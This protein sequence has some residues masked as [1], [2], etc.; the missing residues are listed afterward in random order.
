[1]YEASSPPSTLRKVR[2]YSTLPGPRGAAAARTR[3]QPP[4]ISRQEQHTPPVQAPS[5]AA[6]WD[7]AGALL[8]PRLEMHAYDL[9]GRVR[10]DGAAF[11]RLTELAARKSARVSV[12]P[13][14]NQNQDQDQPSASLLRQPLSPLPHEVSHHLVPGELCKPP[15]SRQWLLAHR[16]RCGGSPL[17]PPQH[18]LLAELLSTSAALASGAGATPSKAVVTEGTAPAGAAKPSPKLEKEYTPDSIQALLA[19]L[20]ETTAAAATPTRP[21]RG[22]RLAFRG[23]PS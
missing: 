17:R 5:S 15:Y 10:E 20:G 21:P 22:G 19:A 7:A 18:P 1:M 2:S 13:Q 4:A 11:G 16:T 12:P 23:E 8:G 14:Q 9:E 6:Q 3:T